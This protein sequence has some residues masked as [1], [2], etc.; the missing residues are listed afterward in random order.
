MQT[1]DGCE[2]EPKSMPNPEPRSDPERN[3]ATDSEL[4]GR[5]SGQ[6]IE[7]AAIARALGHPARVAILRLLARDGSCRCGILV[8]ALPLA[9]A[10]VSQHLR[11]LREAG[12]IQ[13]EVEGPSVCYCVNADTV[14]RL[15]RLVQEL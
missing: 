11:M 12:L 9:Q 14:R 4:P 2:P 6:D 10:T 13:G 1:C 15:Q 8:D 5:F 7:L 3:P